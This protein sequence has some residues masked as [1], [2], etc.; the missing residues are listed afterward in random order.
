MYLKRLEIQGFKTF[1]QKTVVEFRPD[2]S[3][4]R[5][6]TGIVGPNGS[7][8][9]NIADAIR[10]VMGEQSLKLLRGKKS[11]DVIFSGSEKRTRSGFAEVTMVLENDGKIEGVEMGEI[12]ITRRLYRDGQSEYEVNRQA[13]RL[14]DVALLL[15]QCGIGQRTY[16][17]IGQGMVDSVLVASRPSARNFSTKRSVCVRSSSNAKVR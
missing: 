12:A 9:S 11:E 10:W 6:V 15:A 7:G 4:R 13:A 3:G 2:P 14:A 16:S 17:V 1:A 8:K 5:G